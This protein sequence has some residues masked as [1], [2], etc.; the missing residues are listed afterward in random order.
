INLSD[1]DRNYYDDFNLTLAKHPS[2][3][4]SR[5]MFRLVTFLCCADQKL[6]FSK[7]ISTTE[8]PEL[9]QKN[10]SGEVL[11]WIELGLP[12]LKRIKQACG[13]S[14]SVKIFTYQFE[15]ATQWFEKIKNDIE[16]IEKLEIY[17]LKVDDGNSLDELVKKSMTL[18]CLIRDSHLYL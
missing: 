18:S 11:Q 16:S 2:E 7:G 4:E 9:W 17:H 14:Q 10:Y 15:R 3:H 8:E 6:E 12:E 13:K 5:M 1:L